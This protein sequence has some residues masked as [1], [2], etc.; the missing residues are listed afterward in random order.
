[1]RRIGKVEVWQ[2]WVYRA[3]IQCS[4]TPSWVKVCHVRIIK[5]W[6]SL[7]HGHPEGIVVQNPGFVDMETAKE[8]V[9]R[10]WSVPVIQQEQLVAD[11]CILMRRRGLL[12]VFAVV[13]HACSPRGTWCTYVNIKNA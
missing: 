11:D 6:A 1:M 12:R 7:I 5:F 4:C 13:L 3:C 2:V 10:S 8:A 9:G